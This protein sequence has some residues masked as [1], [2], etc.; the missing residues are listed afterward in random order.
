MKT[1]RKF[2]KD[3][4]DYVLFAPHYFAPL[5]YPRSPRG[6]PRAVISGEH[7]RSTRPTPSPGAR[8]PEALESQCHKPRIP[9][10]AVSAEYALLPRHC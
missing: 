7:V 8:R 5:T 10:S 1:R 2:A 4:D 6:Q 9:E 3:N